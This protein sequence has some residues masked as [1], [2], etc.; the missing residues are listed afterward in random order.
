MFAN[1]GAKVLICSRNIAEGE[2]A[3]KDLVANTGAEVSAFKA[4]VTKLEEMQALADAAVER[5]GGLDVLCANAGYFPQTKIED[6]SVDEWDSV[7]ATNLKG[8]FVGVKACLR[9]RRVPLRASSSRRASRGRSPGTLG[10][11]ITALARRGNSA[12]CEPRRSSSPSIRL[13]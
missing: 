1:A 3:A 7:M 6:L 4:D 9:S 2:A 8:S 11:H 5:Y 13:R 10:G 12:S